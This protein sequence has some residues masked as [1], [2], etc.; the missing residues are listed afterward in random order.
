M[1]LKPGEVAVLI[2]LALVTLYFVGRL[3]TDVIL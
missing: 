2:L 3:I 1:I